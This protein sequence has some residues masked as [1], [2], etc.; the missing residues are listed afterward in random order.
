M[1]DVDELES[2]EDFAARARVWLAANMPRTSDDFGGYKAVS[3]TDE[4]ELAHISH[5]R[6][7]QRQLY[8]G[9]FAGICVPRPYGGLGLTPEH[10]LAFNQEIRGYEYP[11]DTQVPTLTPCM[12]VILEFGTDE[13]KKAH[14]PPILKGETFWMQFLS[15]PSG[16]SDLAGAQTTAVRDGD[17][18]I[19]N[20][21][22][23]WTTGAWWADWGLCLARTNWD[24]PKHRGL[25]VFM[26]KINQP[27]I[28]VHRIEMLNGSK[29]FC[30]EFMTDV[31]VPHSQ[32]IGQVD[33]GWGVVV[34]WMFHERT[35]AGG[36]KYVTSPA[37]RPAVALD[38][39]GGPS[40]LIP[41]AKK[42]G[43][44]G[45]NRVKEMIGESLAIT[46][47][48]N[49]LTNRITEEVR[50]GSVSDQAAAITRLW[51]GVTAVRNSTICFELPGATAVAWSD[52]EIEFGKI[53]QRYLMRQAS[54]IAGGTTE[55]ARNAISER[56]LGM[57]SERRVDKDIPFRDVPRSAA[58]R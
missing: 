26:L 5:C 54:C 3:R 32:L 27:G 49:A 55:M 1:T 23:I 48:G 52:D 24:V 21:S 44:L 10:Q 35:I 28:E 11:A 7:L 36:S 18:W 20:G 34:R 47:V 19:L 16:G 58:S 43:I 33:E 6:D 40:A 41:M 17:A 30:Q 50:T 12:S 9:G 15:E 38:P 25:S 29:E 39:T 37:G 13:Q 8:D 14:V 57:P 22:K 4:E 56:V 46:I 45:E 42:R 51:Y 2:V 31:V 53:G